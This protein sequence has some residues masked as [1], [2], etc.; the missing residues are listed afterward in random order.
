MVTR[1]RELVLQEGSSSKFWNLEVDGNKHL[2]HFGRVGSAGQKKIKTFTSPSAA[3]KAFDDLVAE[4]LKKGYS[5]A[6][7]ALPQKTASANGAPTTKGEAPA[8]QADVLTDTTRSIALTDTDWLWATWR[9]PKPAPALPPAP[10]FDRDECLERLATKVKPVQYGWQWSFE[11]AALSP[12]MTKDEAR[13]WFE[14]MHGIDREVSP[15]KKAEQLAKKKLSPI[16]MDGVAKALKKWNRDPAPEMLVVLAALFSPMAVSEMLLTDKPS[17]N[18]YNGGG[19]FFLGWHEHILPRL[20]DTEKET[21]RKRVRPKIKV[22]DFPTDFYDEPSGDFFVAASLGMHDEL[23]A[24]V[25]SWP[26]DHF[27]GEDW[28]DAYHVPQLMIFGLGSAELVN[29]HMRRLKLALREPHY[30]RAWLAHTEYSALDWAAKTVALTKNKDTAAQLAQVLALVRAPENA[31]PMLEVAT[32]SKAPKV[33]AEWLDR[34][35]GHAAAGLVEVAAGRGALADAASERLRALKRAGYTDLIE[36]AAKGASGEAAKKATALLEAKEKALAPMTKPPSWLADALAKTKGLKAVS[37]IKAAQLPTVEIEGEAL[38]PEHADALLSAL[39]SCNENAVKAKAAKSWIHPL[40]TAV[41]DHAEPASRD[42]FAWRLFEAWLTEG[43]PSKEKWALQAVGLLGDDASA[44]KLAPMVRAWPG[45]SQH[46]RAVI[47]LDVLKNIGTDVALMQLS[48]IAQKV[49]FQA[50][51]RRAGECMEAIAKSRKMTRDELEDRIVPD[52][53]FDENGRRILS[54]GARTFE[55]VLGAE[56]A[57]MV[58]ELPQ[59]GGT[60]ATAGARKTDLPK[61]GAKD[62]ADVAN[63]SVAEWKLLKKTLREVTKIQV[64]RLEQAM[65]KGRAWTAKDFDALVV[66]HPLMG[67]LARAVVFGAYDKGRLK[68][69]FRIAE[70][71]TLADD[72][73]EQYKLPKDA[74]VRILHPLDMTDAQKAAWGQVFGDY[75]LL[76]PFAQLGRTVFSLEPKEKKADDLAKRFSGKEWG[77]SAFI[78]KLAR[79][80]WIHG[81]P[82]DAGFVGD[83]A[84]PFFSAGVTAIVEHT[85]YPIGARE[86]ADPQKVERLYFISGTEVP[87]PWT[88][89]KKRLKLDKVD[90]KAV[91]EV[92]LDLS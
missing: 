33:G 53:G 70:D 59:G 80:G 19:E 12:S 44:L 88:S 40:V 78:G 76:A 20:T 55:V 54:F 32:R 34:N 3:Q 91:S 27:Q 14:C 58:R 85:G 52:G 49:K 50:L 79:R 86:Y 60:A 30:M 23:L 68:A 2:L 84:K 90:E 72:K 47:G 45:E 7:G 57:P 48:G 28:N 67:N 89:K 81:E 37:W 39:A 21:L 56:G 66:H 18:G 71:K 17:S 24:L 42:A 83:H 26:D 74:T 25:K 31:G 64:E 77:V 46:A 22:T 15:K 69:T 61:P 73:D 82:Q 65:V 16:T 92:L 51:K 13:F 8:P 6:S 43:A 75:E 11:R 41:H 29:E 62:D 9:K 36:S 10:P 1:A 38:S 63:K 4:K 87:V 35:V 5:D